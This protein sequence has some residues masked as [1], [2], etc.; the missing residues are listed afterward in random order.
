VT[1]EW[2]DSRRLTS[3]GSFARPVSTKP[4]PLLP[5]GAPGAWLFVVKR[6]DGSLWAVDAS[7]V[8]VRSA[9]NA[10]PSRPASEK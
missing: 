4:L 10:P 9:F 6:V 7:R 3:G 2:T 5:L 1:H 8:E